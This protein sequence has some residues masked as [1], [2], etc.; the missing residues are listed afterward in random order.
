MRMQCRVLASC[1][2]LVP[3]WDQFKV[4]AHLGDRTTL[5]TLCVHGRTRW[6]G[7]ERHLT[8]ATMPRGCPQRET[9]LCQK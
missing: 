6:S 2:T 9:Q 4:S 8:S 7:K 3:L 1:S 5:L